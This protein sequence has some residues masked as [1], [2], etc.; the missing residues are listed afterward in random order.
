[1]QAEADA[2]VSTG[3]ALSRPDGTPL[4]GYDLKRLQ[5]C[6]ASC[7]IYRSTAQSVMVMKNDHAR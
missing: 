3:V 6:T 2:A 5:V 4:D 1:V 7:L